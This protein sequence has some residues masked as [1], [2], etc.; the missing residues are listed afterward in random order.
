MSAMNPRGFKYISCGTAAQ[1][2]V[3]TTLTN[4]ISPCTITTSDGA[5]HAG[6][7]ILVADSSFFYVD[8]NVNIVPVAGATTPLAEYNLPVT[9]I[10]DA[11]HI[12]VLNSQPHNAGDWV[13][14]SMQCTT[15]II[16]GK[17]GGA[18]SLWVGGSSGVTNAGVKSVYQIAKVAA[19]SQPSEFNPAQAYT[20]V[21]S[22]NIADFWIVASTGGDQYLP[23]VLV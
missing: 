10:P 3:G 6:Q 5:G 11:T 20:G 1:P 9:A 19:G 14:L 15:I 8:D 13:Q 22:W 12:V 16:Q 18:G 21:H 17:D 2:V 4:A 7:S 23:S